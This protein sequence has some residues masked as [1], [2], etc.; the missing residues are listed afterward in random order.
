MPEPLTRH[1]LDRAKCAVPGC[2]HEDHRL[3]YFVARCHPSAKVHAAYDLVA[4]VMQV[5]CGK[6]K[7]PVATIK[8]AE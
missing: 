4:G 3:L 6:C 2:T 5:T 1:Q 7:R 8:V